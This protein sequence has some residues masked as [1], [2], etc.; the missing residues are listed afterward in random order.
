[1]FER[2]SSALAGESVP[3]HD[4]STAV[5]NADHERSV[6]VTPAWKVV[7]G[8]LPLLGGAAGLVLDAIV[9][10]KEEEHDDV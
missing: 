9:Q 5:R 8:L 7:Y 4:C 3:P 1:M 2:K 10:C 6:A